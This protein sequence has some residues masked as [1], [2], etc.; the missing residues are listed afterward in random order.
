MKW[1][2]A[3]WTRTRKND[4]YPP[5]TPPPPTDRGGGLSLRAQHCES[6]RSIWAGVAPVVALGKNQSRNSSGRCTG[7]SACRGDGNGP[8]GAARGLDRV[9]VGEMGSKD[10]DESGYDGA[11]RDAVLLACGRVG[12]VKESATRLLAHIRSGRK[13]A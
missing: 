2:G 5:S 8:E 7:V 10:G 4:I 1:D 3:R 9:N 11:G 12:D 13:S 6:S